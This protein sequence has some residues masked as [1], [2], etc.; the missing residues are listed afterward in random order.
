MNLP[1][2]AHRNIC[3]SWFSY[4]RAYPVRALDAELNPPDFSPATLYSILVIPCAL[5]VIGVPAALIASFVDLSVK[6]G[7]CNSNNKSN[8]ST[9]TSTSNNVSNKNIINRASSTASNGNRRL[10]GRSQR[11]LIPVL[12]LHAGVAQFS[13]RTEYGS[14]FDSNNRHVIYR[15]MQYT[16]IVDNL[17]SV[18]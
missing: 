16:L 14:K 9:S 10:W 11:F 6:S 7:Q 8:N 4:C 12:S 13:P 3:G 17:M 2:T 18:R 5:R 1:S 15:H